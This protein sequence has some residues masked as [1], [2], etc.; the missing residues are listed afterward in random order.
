MTIKDDREHTEKINDLRVDINDL[1]NKLIS[2]SDKIENK[3]ILIG[4]SIEA[5]EKDQ[6]GHDKKLQ[7]LK[8]TVY[9]EIPKTI[10]EISKRIDELTDTMTGLANSVNTMI[11]AK[12]TLNQYIW[13]IIL[14]SII[15]FITYFIKDGIDKF[16]NRSTSKS[17][18]ETPSHTGGSI[19]NANPLPFPGE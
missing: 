3:C 19:P 13:K 1:Q 11:T 9:Q 8:V 10:H 2:V 15:C 6:I 18:L 14:A 5:V 16:L 4:K 17:H 7:E 12:N